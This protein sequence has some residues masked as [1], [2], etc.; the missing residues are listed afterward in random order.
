MHCNARS[1]ARWLAA[2]TAMA[3][4]LLLTAVPVA[5]EDATPGQPAIHGSG[6]L[7]MLPNYSDIGEKID[8]I[9]WV[10]FW[11]TTIVFVAVQ[12]VMIWF[13]VKYRERPGVPRTVVYSHGDQKLEMWWTA[14]PSVILVVLALW[15]NS[16]WDEARKRPPV[17]PVRVQVVGKQFAWTFVY[18]GP[19]GEWDTE[20]DLVEGSLTLAMGRPALFRITSLDVLHSFFLPQ[21][22]LKQDALPRGKVEVWMTPLVTGRFEVACAEFCGLEHGNMRNTLT[23]LEPAEF[24]KWLS[25]K[26]NKPKRTV[27]YE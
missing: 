1:S 17:D 16:V 27:S 12:S 2:A 25:D 10:I 13:L 23:V 24:D 14:I 26:Q 18:P 4:F 15:N 9:F 6:L 20:D 21:F 8:R 11:L 7:M 19:D 3:V 22:R 5:A